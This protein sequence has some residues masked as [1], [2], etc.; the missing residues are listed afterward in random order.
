LTRRLSVPVKLFDLRSEGFELV[1]GRLLPD[2]NGPSAQLMYQDAMGQ[3][4]TVYL[5]KS[6]R[7]PTRRSATTA[8]VISGCSIGSTVRADMRWSVRS[9][10]NV[11]WL[12]LRPSPSRIGSAKADAAR[13][14]APRS[15]SF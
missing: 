3:R 13:I 2:A 15:A 10:V 14:A 9:R 4:V 8:R 11:C 12:W 5:R 6:I 1:G 7:R